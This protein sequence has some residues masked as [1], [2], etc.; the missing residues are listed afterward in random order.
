MKALIG[1]IIGFGLLVFVGVAGFMMYAHYNNTEVR[2]RNEAKAQQKSNETSFDTCWKIISQQAQVA[3]SHKDAFRQIY[4]DVMEKRYSG[5]DPLLS[6]IT[7]TNPGFDMKLYEKVSN[8]IEGQRTIFKRDQ[9]RLIDI[10][11]QHDDIRMTVPGSFF[12]GGR[13]EIEIKIVT[14]SKAD[15]AFES[16]KDDDTNVFPTKATAPV[17]KK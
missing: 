16:G 2:L 3:E 5:K 4:V 14:S 7:E 17:E 1:L 9:Q 8:S 13:P 10:K 11:R 15:A 6:F 12:V